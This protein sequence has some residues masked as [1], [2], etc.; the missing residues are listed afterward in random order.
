MSMPHQTTKP[1]RGQCT[2][3]SFAVVLCGE[4]LGQTK[5]NYRG[6]RVPTSASAI[7][8]AKDSTVKI[9][10]ALQ[11]KPSPQDTLILG[12]TENHEQQGPFKECKGQFQNMYQPEMI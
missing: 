12:N 5:I 6:A 7:L 2:R 3:E 8:T 10:K 1:E 4:R 9:R 11:R